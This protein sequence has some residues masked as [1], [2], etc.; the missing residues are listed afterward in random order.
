MCSIISHYKQQPLYEDEEIS[1]VDRPIPNNAN[2][3]SIKSTGFHL[4]FYF[5][6]FKLFN[7]NYEIRFKMY[8]KA[9]KN[10]SNKYQQWNQN[11]LGTIE[12]TRNY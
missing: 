9:M 1:I 4:K 7:R 5:I 6:W 12:S 10:C 2:N 3:R 8:N 11:H